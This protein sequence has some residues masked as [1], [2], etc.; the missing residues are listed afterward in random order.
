MWSICKKELAQFFSNLTG[1]IAIV[2]F[3]LVNGV[4]LFMLPDSSIFEYGYA[5]LDKFFELAP[6]VLL[7]LVP[8]ITMRSFSDEFRGGTFEILKTKPLTSA[9][10]TTGKYVA[11]LIVLVFVIIPT[12]IYIITISSLSAS[13]GIDKGGIIGSYIGLFLLAAV[14]AA[15][16][17][18]CSS[19]TSNA[20]V[21]FLV[22]AFVCLL[23][24]FGFN[25]L[26]NLPV[27]QGNADYYIE[28]LGIDFHYRSI[29]RAVLDSRDVVY[30][31]SII[32][33]SLLITVKNLQKR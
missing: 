20:V 32:F 27:F 23:L 25:A 7:F 24:Y 13:G 9:Q 5:S 21:A 30:F 26:S 33:L 6:W 4:F 2:L 10:I 8:A 16:S 31:F 12:F 1:Y 11:V 18:C 14:F 29:S 19:F 3:L 15:I 28:M 22:S 17:L